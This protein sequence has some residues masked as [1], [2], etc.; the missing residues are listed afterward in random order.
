[1]LSVSGAVLSK[2][3]DEFSCGLVQSGRN[4]CS[5]R[6]NPKDF[7]VEE[8]LSSAAVVLPRKSKHDVT[9]VT[10]QTTPS[11]RMNNRHK[12]LA[13]CSTVLAYIL[14]FLGPLSLLCFL[15]V[16]VLSQIR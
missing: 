6:M 15:S 3:E 10:F 7:A 16:F 14:H 1:M 13:C 12:K 9:L 8:S 4:E 2:W 11:L 5:N